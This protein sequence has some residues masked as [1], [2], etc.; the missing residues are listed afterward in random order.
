MAY[1]LITEK[2]VFLTFSTKYLSFNRELLNFQNHLPFLNSDIIK[3]SS[4]DEWS[5]LYPD[6]ISILSTL[7]SDSSVIR[8]KSSLVLIIGFF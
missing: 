5:V 3:S 1:F 8:K 4:T 2:I 7:E 6:L